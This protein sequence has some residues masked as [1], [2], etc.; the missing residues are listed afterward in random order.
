MSFGTPWVFADDMSSE[1]GDTFHTSTLCE[2]GPLSVHEDIGYL[3]YF[4][5]GSVSTDLEH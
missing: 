5:A 2:G 3:A 4:D 1:Y